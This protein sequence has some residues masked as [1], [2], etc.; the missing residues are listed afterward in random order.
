MGVILKSLIFKADKETQRLSQYIF[1]TQMNKFFR[2]KEV[3]FQTI[4]VFCY[5]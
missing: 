5:M 2:E 3:P 1:L 4:E